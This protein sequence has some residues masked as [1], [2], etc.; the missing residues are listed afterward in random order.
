MASENIS[1]T[2]ENVEI[3][4][5]DTIRKRI[6]TVKNFVGMGPPDLCCMSSNSIKVIDF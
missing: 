1:D 4:L 2:P 6:E 5:N 3:T